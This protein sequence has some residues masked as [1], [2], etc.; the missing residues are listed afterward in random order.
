MPVIK[1]K[2]LPQKQYPEIKSTDIMV[3]EDSDDTYQITVEALMLFFSNDEKLQSIIN[4]VEEIYK[5][6]DKAIDSN[7]F[8][9]L[10]TSK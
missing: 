1:I 6:L 3:I 10:K 4:R 9:I 8:F 2:E 7:F 5:E